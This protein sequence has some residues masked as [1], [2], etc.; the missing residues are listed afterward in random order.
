M[1]RRLSLRTRRTTTSRT[2]EA[3][4]YFEAGEDVYVHIHMIYKCLLGKKGHLHCC[5]LTVVMDLRPG[6]TLVLEVPLEYTKYTRSSDTSC[7]LL[8]SALRESY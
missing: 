8:I 4:A 3:A 6:Y 2:E 7:A 5:H 1:W